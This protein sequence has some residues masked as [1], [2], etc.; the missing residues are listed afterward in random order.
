MRFREPIF[1]QP[2]R[3]MEDDHI[4][5][6]IDDYSYYA[7]MQL[8]DAKRELVEHNGD[9]IIKIGWMHVVPLHPVRKYQNRP[10]KITTL[11]YG[12]SEVFPNIYE[13]SIKKGFSLY[14]LRELMCGRGIWS[15][16][17]IA[18]YI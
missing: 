4:C 1:E 3:V 13:A 7:G 17:F 9:E 11:R 18:E 16:N 10:I 5:Q 14:S 6:D 2:M 8:E 12:T 15:S